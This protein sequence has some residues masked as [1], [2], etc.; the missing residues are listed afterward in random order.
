MAEPGL[1]VHL[2]HHSLLSDTWKVPGAERGVLLGCRGVASSACEKGGR[3][4]ELAHPAQPWGL[5]SPASGM[6]PTGNAHLS[7]WVSHLPPFASAPP[8]FF[9]FLFG[10]SWC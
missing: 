1:P 5:G 6:V 2:P 10:A 8:I 7:I 3:D 4:R 9:F